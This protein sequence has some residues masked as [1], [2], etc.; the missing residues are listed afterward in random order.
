ME[1]T[2]YDVFI[3][4]SRKDIAVVQKICSF[5]N[6]Y[7]ISYWIDKK[8]I[9]A[10]GEFLGE[11]VKAIKD[12]KI[13]LFISSADSNN[14]VYTAKEVAMAFNE[15]KYII[16]YKIDTSTFNKNLELVLCD[17]NWVEAI[18]FD[19]AKALELVLNIKSLLTGYRRK[20]V[21]TIPR[22]DY[23]NV[24]DWDQPSNRVIKYIKNIFK[25]KS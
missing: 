11:I 20:E 1:Q 2:K 7:Q 14:S 5:F 9:H 24:D 22:R 25:E 17:L 18:P 21:E 12:C 10:G 15:G 23:I 16:P 3:S 19:E 6:T 4:Y 13:T 8:N